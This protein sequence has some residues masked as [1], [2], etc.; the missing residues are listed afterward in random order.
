MRK[1]VRYRDRR[2][3]SVWCL[4]LQIGVERRFW[5]DTTACQRILL[6][7]RPYAPLAAIA[8]VLD[9]V[10]AKHAHGLD[11]RLDRISQRTRVS[12]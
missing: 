8:N 7:L 12:R 1:L 6:R 2:R 10:L 5:D 9:G 3:R 4:S 11:Q